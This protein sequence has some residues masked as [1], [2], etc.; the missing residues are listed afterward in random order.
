MI[1]EIK[2][3]NFLIKINSFGAQIESIVFAGE[4]RLWDNNDGSWEDHFPN[5]FPFAGHVDYVYNGV[6]YNIKPHGFAKDYEFIL[7]NIC[8]DSI[9][10]KLISNEEI[11]SFFP[12]D[13]EFIVTY[14]LQDDTI[15]FSYKVNNLGENSLY[16]AVGGHESFLLCDSVDKYSVEFEKEES[17]VNLVNDDNGYLT[18]ES[19]LIE[20]T[21]ELKLDEKYF[22]NG[23]SLI[24][25]NLKS[26]FVNLRHNGKEVA[27]VNFKGFSTMLL[28]KQPNSNF[29]CIEPWLNLPDSHSNRK[30]KI[31]D[32]QG[33]I[34][35]DG[36]NSKEITQSIKYYK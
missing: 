19:K 23:A 22:I 18:G 28:W 3:K 5:L 21:N 1:Y 34:K 2:N 10:L 30:D 12:F 13:F 4:E 7:N 11:K 32:K 26:T 27:T 25:D 6:E 17:L 16:F 31:E 20:K 14:A 9:S 36:K 33:F 15:N 29:I 8:E 24:F 35:V